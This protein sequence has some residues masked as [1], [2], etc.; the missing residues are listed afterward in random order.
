MAT[1]RFMWWIIVENDNF[2]NFLLIYYNGSIRAFF[3]TFHYSFILIFFLYFRVWNFVT[4]VHQEVVWVVHFVFF[5]RWYYAFCKQN[6]QQV[7]LRVIEIYN[8]LQSFIL[9]LRYVIY[10][11]SQ[12]LIVMVPEVASERVNIHH[13]VPGVFPIFDDSC[14][15]W[16]SLVVNVSLRWESS[17]L[18]NHL[19]HF[20][21]G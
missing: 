7:G 6:C 3:F 14:I 12:Y 20:E 4:F 13:A 17:C 18:K 9:Y 5:P 15:F 2:I 11:S 16:A 19:I 1:F 10:L 8:C 21:G